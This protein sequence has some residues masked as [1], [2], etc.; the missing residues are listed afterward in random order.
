MLLALWMF[1]HFSQFLVIW[2]ANEPHEAS[3]YLH[4]IGG[5]GA[6]CLW[7]AVLLLVLAPAL[8][9]L[10]VTRQLTLRRSVAAVAGLA[11]LVR[12]LEDFWLI[13]PSF[14]GGFTLSIA[15]LLAAAGV[16]ALVVGVQ[17]TGWLPDLGRRRL[18]RA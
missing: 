12:L 9:L 6:A 4:R 13:T 3:W 14:R 11:L 5:L 1:L 10:P 15:D 17:L 2:S 18:V 8:L 16:L 7:L